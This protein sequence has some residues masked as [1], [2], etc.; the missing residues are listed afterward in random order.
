[1]NI[2]QMMIPKICTVF[3]H[4][5]NTIRQGLEVMIRHGYT[6]IPVLN[7]N[8]KYFGSVSEGDFL[9]WVLQNETIDKKVYEKHYIDEIMKKDSLKSLNFNAD[10]KSVIQA[11]IQQNFVPITDARGIL[12][13]ILTRKSVIEYLSRS[14]E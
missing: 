4:E 12:S 10:G 9:R 14:T 11:V 5:T 7:S 13:G 3:L 8:E 6:V 2:A 1:M